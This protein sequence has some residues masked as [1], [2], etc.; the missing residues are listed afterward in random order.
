MKK[1]RKRKRERESKSEKEREKGKMRGWKVRMKEKGKMLPGSRA[2]CAREM[3]RYRR[4]ERITK[5]KRERERRGMIETCGERKMG[6][7]NRL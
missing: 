1:L 2:M 3:N 7:I 4:I 6:E 5:R